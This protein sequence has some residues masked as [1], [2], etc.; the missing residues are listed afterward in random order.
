MG[1]TQIRCFLPG[2]RD[3]KR[4]CTYAKVSGVGRAQ[5][6]EALKYRTVAE[7]AEDPMIKHELLELADVC[8]EV[9]NNIGDAI[10]QR[11]GPHVWSILHV[12]EAK[13]RLSAST[14]PA[15]HLRSARDL[16]FG[17]R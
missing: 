5:A 14:H 8:D 6:P 2:H 17:G 12:L 3:S 1:K 11:R 4:A 7:Q 9:A 13:D 15:Y 10:N 16:Q